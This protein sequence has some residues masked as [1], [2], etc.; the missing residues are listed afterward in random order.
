MDASTSCSQVMIPL[1]Q[2]DEQLYRVRH[3]IDIA[4]Q[5]QQVSVLSNDGLAFD[6]NRKLHQLV[7]QE[8][9][10]VHHLYGNQMSF[11]VVVAE[12]QHQD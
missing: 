1:H 5:R 11:S 9:V 10:H 12:L 4:I 2:I 7:A 6:G 3:E 8:V